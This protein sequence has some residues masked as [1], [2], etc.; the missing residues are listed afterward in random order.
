MKERRRMAYEW[1]THG[2]YI[3]YAWLGLRMAYAWLG[4]RMAY[5]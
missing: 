4:L 2:L 5:T 1:L 3:A